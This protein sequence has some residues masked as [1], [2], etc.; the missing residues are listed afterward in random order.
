MLYP[1]AHSTACSVR[2]TARWVS[3]T[4][5]RKLLHH[6]HQTR[7][8][9]TAVAPSAEAVTEDASISC[10]GMREAKTEGGV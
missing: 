4:N 6:F 2:H 3:Q 9:N 10:Q 1:A 8:S 7:A 5:A